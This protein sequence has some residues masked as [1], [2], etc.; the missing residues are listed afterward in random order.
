MRPDGL[1]CVGMEQ[2]ARRPA[3]LGDLRER[4]NHPGLVVRRHHRN[5]EGTIIHCRGET[6]KV[7]QA[8]GLHRKNDDFVARLPEIH[9]GIQHRRVLGRQR[10]DAS[11]DS[12]CRPDRAPQCKIARL[13]GPRRKNDVVVAC[14]DEACDSGSS[15]PNRTC[16][17]P[18]IGMAVG[19]AD[20]Q[21]DR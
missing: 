19:G 3:Q 14:A 9:H 16:S 5:D 15:F 20:S 10:D 17:F 4:L 7:D 6:L 2:R 11:S 13:G 8:V 21:T 18:S 12:L 1:R